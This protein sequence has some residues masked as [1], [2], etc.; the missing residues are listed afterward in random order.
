MLSKTSSAS[1]D[2]VYLLLPDT[3]RWFQEISSWHSCLAVF[4]LLRLQHVLQIRRRR[5]VL[6]KMF[7]RIITQKKTKLASF[8]QSGLI[9]D[10]VM[11]SK[12]DDVFHDRKGQENIIL[13][14]FLYHSYQ[15]SH[16]MGRNVQGLHCCRWY[17]IVN[18]GVLPARKSIHSLKQARGLFP[19]TGE[20][21]MLY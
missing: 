6:R 3:R 16:V 19:R 12:F 2:N 5:Y 4:R 18:N 17:I 9:S 8:G 21:A 10:P 1:T 7:G 15:L 13:N 11:V 20:Q 14:P